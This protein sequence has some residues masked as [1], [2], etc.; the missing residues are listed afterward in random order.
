[1]GILQNAINQTLGFGAVAAGV[2]SQTPA[3][4]SR[5]KTF[6]ADKLLEAAEKPG[7][8]DMYLAARAQEA[9]EEAYVLDPTNPKLYE[10]MD[11]SI[12]PEIANEARK[13]AA[14]IQEQRRAQDEQSKK[15]RDI[16]TQGGLYK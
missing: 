13:R 8:D 3:G 6:E 4:K 14:E 7:T 16:F 9:Y 1:M 15:F 10:Y 11:G 2:Y 5:R 12:D